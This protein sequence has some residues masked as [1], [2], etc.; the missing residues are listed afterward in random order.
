MNIITALDVT[1]LVIVL[2]LHDAPVRQQ[3]YIIPHFVT[4]GEG[5]KKCTL[6]CDFKAQMKTI[7]VMS[8]CSGNNA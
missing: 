1:A 6:H 4:K 3:V 2:L 5:R 7:V 8:K